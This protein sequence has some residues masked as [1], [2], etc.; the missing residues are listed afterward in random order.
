MDQLQLTLV[1]QMI[2]EIKSLNTSAQSSQ[3]FWSGQLHIQNMYLN[4]GIRKI[5]ITFFIEKDLGLV[6]F[7]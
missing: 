6:N 4:Y 3:S 5:I 1:T 7:L 2:P